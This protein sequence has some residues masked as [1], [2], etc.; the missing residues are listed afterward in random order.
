MIDLRLRRLRQLPLWAILLLGA[1]AGLAEEAPEATDLAA[2][3]NSPT[4]VVER[5]HAGLLESM[6]NADEFGFQGRFEYI[7][8]VVE[9]TFD[10]G[11][12]GSKSVGRHWKKLN[13]DEQEE[14]LDKF[15]G[16]IAA[17]YAGNFD[18]YDGESFATLGEQPAKRDTR[19]VLTELR[20]PGGD[21]VVFNYRLRETAGGWRI[22]DIYLKGTVSE[23]A[24]RRSDFSSTLK[25]KGFPELT[26]AVDRKIVELQ[27]NGGG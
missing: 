23:L 4:A 1:S 10:L 24:L 22:I 26:A 12:M 21:D 2:A 20:V 16:F 17:N 13:R 27:E 6:K 18:S 25:A 19:V 7:R 8:P 5:L 15:T 11:F 3:A 9:E 14:W